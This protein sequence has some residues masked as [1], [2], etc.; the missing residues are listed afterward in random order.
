VVG[1]MS[2]A[3]VPM[4]PRTT[5]ARAVRIARRTSMR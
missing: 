2:I 5:F 1:L 3:S 4:V